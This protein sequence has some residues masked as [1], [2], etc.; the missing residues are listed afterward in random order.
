MNKAKILRGNPIKVHLAPLPH[1]G[2]RLHS[3]NFFELMYVKNGKIKQYANGVYQELYPGDFILLEPCDSHEYI[4]ETINDQDISVINACFTATGIDSS[5]HECKSLSML[6]EHPVFN[7]FP[8]DKK[9][10]PSCR[11][12]HDDNNKIYN[13]IAEIGSELEKASDYSILFARH[14]LIL[15]L[16]TIMSEYTNLDDCDKKSE[17]PQ[18]MITAIANRYNEPNL[19]INLS[20]ELNYSISF[21][22]TLFKKHYD[23]GF[24][25]C[26][27]NYRID[28]AKHLLFST[29]MSIKDIS[30]AVGYSQTRYFYRL[31]KTY[32]QLTP[33]E[34]RTKRDAIYDKK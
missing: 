27:Q 21:L 23:T 34:F 20:K 9:L 3:H 26:L 10:L 15:L 30:L 2:T 8:K 13:L 31:F 33:T 4:T 6:L 19:L 14:K 12:M 29:S 24:K 28:Q 11:V 17:I 5:M 32:T 1:I 7:D 18:I 16:F 22:S 25:E